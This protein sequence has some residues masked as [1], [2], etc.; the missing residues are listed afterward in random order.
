MT[1]Y[2]SHCLASGF[3]LRYRLFQVGLR[4][5]CTDCYTRLSAMGMHIDPVTDEPRQR[6]VP[7]AVDRRV[8]LVRFIANLRGVA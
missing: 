5:L 6:D 3:V 2:C 7:V 4:Y 1:G 8:G